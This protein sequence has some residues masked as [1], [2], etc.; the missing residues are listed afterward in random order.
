MNPKNAVRDHVAPATSVGP[1]LLVASL[2][3]S[4]GAGLAPQPAAGQELLSPRL[5]DAGG[6]AQALSAAD[7]QG[8]ITAAAGAINDSTMAVAVVDR[9]GT[10]LGVWAR[11]GATGAAIPAGLTRA[12]I[13]D[14][15]VST[16]RTTA[17]FSND[18]APL[19][20]RTV[21]FISG[22]HFPPGIRNTANAPLYGV[23]N[24]NRGCTLDVLGP[25]IFNSPIDR[26]RSIDGTLDP[27]NN[28]CNPQSQKGCAV[29]LPIRDDEVSPSKL[30]YRLGISTGKTD[31]RDLTSGE[32]L[33]VN[34]GG[35]PLFRNNKLIGGVGVAGV[36]PE[37]A[38]F[39][40]LV[41]A[42]T[43]VTGI[44]TAINFPN[45]LPSPGAIYI[46]GLKL[47]F[48]NEGSENR[49]DGSTAGSIT[50]GSFIIGPL[51]GRQAPETYTIGPRA[52]VTG[53]ANKLT[54]ADVTRIVNQARAQADLTRA[55]VRLPLTQKASFIIAVTD[56]GGN[57]LA[58]YRQVDALFDA[59]DVVP[60][61]ARNAYYFSTREG[62][63]VLKS[64][65]G[66][67]ANYSW[68]P[69]PPAGQG[70]A[71]T[72]RT[73]SF[74]GQPL[75]PPGID[76][77]SPPTPGPWFG[78]FLYDT[79][80]PCTEGN[81][82]SRGGN[83][84]FLNQNGITWFPGSVPLY[85]NGELVGGLGVSGDGVEQNDLVSAAGGAGFEPPP[86]LRVDNSFIT[87]NGN[88]IRL[89]YL[90]FPRNPNF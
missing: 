60:S 33:A 1:R 69:D 15:A 20:S 6:P 10:I 53:T 51:S 66:E 77:E 26:A 75:F 50:T 31:L 76:L 11:P 72:S 85:K 46:G 70:W 19:S 21:R 17:Y 87:Y 56:Q 35:I 45:P 86:S 5:R 7:V 55:G 13:P 62:Y 27:V 61:K 49:P 29:G 4:L 48:K 63:E 81:G 65:L 88:S 37:R 82:P 41:G 34:P 2:V 74:G 16:A 84:A 67:F 47:P 90:K 8:I 9:A 52:A 23:E 54:L 57:I 14:I 71:L 36:S 32:E 80:N 30:L 83:R 73:L 3:L 43:G 68:T 12:P 24:I 44:T 79:R 39:A 22:I 18:Q 59:V 38:E 25:A 42:I 40:A 78:L 64:Y 89:P 58:E 28:P